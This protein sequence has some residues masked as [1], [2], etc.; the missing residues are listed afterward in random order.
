MS[1]PHDPQEQELLQHDAEHERPRKKSSVL[2]YLVIL[3]AAAF[4][5]LLMSYFMQQ[6]TSEEAID[7]LKQTSISAVQSLDQLLQ[8]RDALQVQ[9]NEMAGQLAALQDETAALVED[10]EAMRADA[11]LANHA[12]AAMAW[13][14][15]I[16]DYYARGYHTDARK[17]IDS[18]ELTG[19]KTS[20]PAENTIGTDRFSPA[21]RYQEIYDALY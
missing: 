14:W 4:A 3:F 7:G 1:H 21:Q 16:D 2:F 20:L 12:L 15:Q 13:F 11:D 17:L 19:L 9:V 5:L 8:E 18:F 10:A 6:R